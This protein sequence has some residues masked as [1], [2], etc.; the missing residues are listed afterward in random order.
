M[1]YLDLLQYS[2]SVYGIESEGCWIWLE[3]VHFSLCAYHLVDTP[4]TPHSSTHVLSLLRA[5]NYAI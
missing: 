2:P 4:P 5:P 3:R 1:S